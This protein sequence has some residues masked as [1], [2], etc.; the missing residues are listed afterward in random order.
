MGLFSTSTGY[1]V[2]AV[3]VGV[4]STVT[5]VVYFLPFVIRSF[6]F[7]AAVWS[8]LLFIL[9]IAV[10]GVFASLF[11]H[12]DSDGDSA[13]RRMRSAVWVDL[14]NAL[15]WLISALSIFG[16]WWKHRESRSQ[17]TGRAQV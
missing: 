15:L 6:G 8:G 7:V 13:I 12:A 9:W 5:C 2:Y 4:L 11:I 1:F 3:V 17:F 16:Y 10:F 14:V